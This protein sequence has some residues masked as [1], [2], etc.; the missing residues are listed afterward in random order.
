MTTGTQHWPAP[1]DPGR[2][3]ERTR[4]AWRRTVL[5]VTVVGL[6]AI[7]LAVQHPS[8]VVAVL[9]VAATLAGWLGLLI[10]GWRRIVAMAV[11]EPAPAGRAMPLAALATVGFAGLGLALV[12]THLPR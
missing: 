11:A 1:R 3:P 7:R 2:Q 10:L 8:P 5:A 6:L 4:L 12:A 9:A